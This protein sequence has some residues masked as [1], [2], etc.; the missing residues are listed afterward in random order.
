VTKELDQLHKQNCIAPTDVSGLTVSEKKNT[1]QALMLLAEK[2][3]IKGQCV[4][5]GN[6]TREWLGKED[7]A[8]PNMAT[9]SI[10]LTASI[11]T[12]E[13]CNITTADVPH[14]FIQTLSSL[15]GRLEMPPM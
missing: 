8:S 13:K 10:I 9:D 7:V 14:A 6:P 15:Q 5:T 1:Q 12:T 4:Y 2:K 11:D 3:D